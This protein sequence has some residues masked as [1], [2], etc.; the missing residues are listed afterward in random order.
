MRLSVRHLPGWQRWR[1]GTLWTGARQ[2][3]S[4]INRSAAAIVGGYA[5][6]SAAMLLLAR[7]SPSPPIDRVMTSLMMTYPCYAAVI[8]WGF[9][10]HSVMRVWL[11][12]AIGTLGCSLLAWMAGTGQ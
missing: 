11:W 10:A 3:C 6:T 1:V 9:A 2:L 7:I 5:F 4:A 12:L 8:I